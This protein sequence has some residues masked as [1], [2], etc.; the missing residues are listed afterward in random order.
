MSLFCLDCR[1]GDERQLSVAAAFE[2]EVWQL[3]V[4]VAPA[5]PVP[6]ENT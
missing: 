1:Q 2:V 3:V 4:R 5:D 6:S